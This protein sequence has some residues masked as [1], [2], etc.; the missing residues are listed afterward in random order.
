MLNTGHTLAP[1]FCGEKRAANAG[2]K[3]VPE[4]GKNIFKRKGHRAFHLIEVGFAG[5]ITQK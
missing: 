4:R 5:N 2:R 3:S 1:A